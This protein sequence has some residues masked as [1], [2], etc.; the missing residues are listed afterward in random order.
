[1][2]RTAGR[3][4]R[5]PPPGIKA[6]PYPLP[7]P[8]GAALAGPTMCQPVRGPRRPGKAQPP[9]GE[10]TAQ[11]SISLFAMRLAGLQLLC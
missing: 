2:A 7:S 10:I 4:R 1:M 8:G 5:Q 9:P 6:A 3:V 11:S